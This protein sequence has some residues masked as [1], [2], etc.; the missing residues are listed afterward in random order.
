MPRVYSYQRFSDPRQAAGS[1]SERQADY[2]RRWAAGRGLTLDE[3]L[4][5]RDDGLSAYH[6][7]HVKSGALGVFLRAAEDGLIEPGSVLVVEGLD[8]LSRAEPLQA[9][10]QLTQIIN[11][12]I[13]VVTAAD[14]QEYSREAIR[15][16][17]YKLIHSLVVMIRAHEESDT[18]SKRVRAAV[19]R[20]C[21]AWLAGTYRGVIR[22][23]RDPGWLRQV[24]QGWEEI[25]V[26]AEAWRWALA[27]YL[28]GM[29]GAA[30]VRAVN[31]RWPDAR[32][33]MLA[34]TLYKA[35]RNPMLIGT[36]RFDIDGTHFDL[37]G[38]YPPLVDLETWDHLQIASD[39]RKGKRGPAEIPSMLT[40]IGILF[41]GYCGHAVAAQNL[42]SRK[43]QADGRPQPGHRRLHCVGHNAGRPC[44]GGSIQA[45]VVERAVVLYCTDTLRLE[46][47]R[48]GD[49]PAAALR[50]ELAQTR[51]RG[52]TRRALAERLVDAL[53][54]DGGEAPR[55]ML[56]RVRELEREADEADTEAA[57]IERTLA[58][59]DAPQASDQPARW[60]AL[61]AGIEALETDARMEARR[62]MQETFARV[63]L[64]HRG[65]GEEG[66]VFDL[67]LTL[68]GGGEMRM[69][70]DRGSGG[71]VDAVPQDHS[72]ARD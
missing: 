18:K 72:A 34:T 5:M 6:Q 24:G 46:A 56:V 55:A 13:T 38:Y 43:R 35:V 16:N 32:V 52:R 61:L 26:M 14:G 31:T 47:A 53:A 20:Q 70:F 41:C 28:D 22:N 1:S 69:R 60:L 71:L 17:P 8:R 4:S 9:Q 23:G 51:E 45:G 39:Q 66:D 15:A 57:R 7:R 2:A 64:W 68:R 44:V 33:K 65:R 27:R 19:R 54:E 58:T 49:T 3:S 62:M 30:I 50:A 10:A 11:A 59:L 67:E 36:R 29:G 21:E 12:G 40:G 42:M 48:A 37:P 63:V 25:P